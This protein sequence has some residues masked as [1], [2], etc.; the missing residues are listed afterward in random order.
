MK[1][2]AHTKLGNHGSP[3]PSSKGNRTHENTS[4]DNELDLTTCLHRL[5]RPN[6]MPEARVPFYDASGATSS[7]DHSRCI[8]LVHAEARGRVEKPASAFDRALTSAKSK[9]ICASPRLRSGVGS[10]PSRV[11]K[12]KSSRANG[13]SPKL[14]CVVSVRLPGASMK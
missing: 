7:R 6:H 10:R 2:N 3:N 13:S 14:I 11:P 12:A 5:V 8:N 9:V 4:N 1:T